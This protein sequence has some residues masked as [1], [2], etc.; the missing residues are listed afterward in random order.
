[1]AAAKARAVLE[2]SSP[3][4]AVRA[5]CQRLA[6]NLLRPRRT[7]GNDDYF[8]TVLFLLAECFF[9]RERV[10][11]IHFVGDV[12]ADPGTGLVQLERSVLLRHLFHADQNL[13]AIT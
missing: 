5:F 6:Q 9:E 2:A 4:N 8:P 10:R 11:F 12:L 1:M 13:H 3:T 7:G